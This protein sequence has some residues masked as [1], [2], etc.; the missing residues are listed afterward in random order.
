M[1]HATDLQ[2]S[3]STCQWYQCCSNTASHTTTTAVSSSRSHC[4]SGRG[5]SCVAQSKPHVLT[6][7]AMHDLQLNAQIADLQ[8]QLEGCKSSLRLALKGDAPPVAAPA[9]AASCPPCAACPPAADCPACP[10][11][12]PAAAA[13]AA[14]SPRMSLVCVCVMLVTVCTNLVLIPRP[15]QQRQVVACHTLSLASPQ[16]P[17]VAARTT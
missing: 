11:A 15:H 14:P 9:P 8:Q 7:P 5:S 10:S 13:V 2:C 1:G 6:V 4:S 17:G 16:C 3:S 12:P